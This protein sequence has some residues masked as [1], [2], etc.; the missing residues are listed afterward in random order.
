M[1]RVKIFGAGSIG[2]HLAH[3][4]RT[5]GATVTVCD[6]SGDALERMR[7]DIYPSRYKQWDEGIT[8]SSVEAQPQGG[9]DLICI[10]TPPDSHLPLALAA[11]EEQ[12]GAILIE[13]PACPP[14]LEGAQA[15]IDGG[16]K[17]STQLFIGYDHVV[18]RAALRVEQ[19]MHD[20]AVGDVRT[21]DVE[22][23]EHWQGIFKAHPWLNGPADTYLGFWKRGG[24]ASG[25]HSHA[26]NLWQH[27]AHV[28]GGGRVT[29]TDCLLT[30]VQ[31]GAAHFDS[32]CSWNLRTE[33]GLVGRVVQDVVTLPARKRAV[34][35]GVD[36]AIE[37][38]NGHSPEGDAVIVHRPGKAPEVETVAKKRPDDFI[39]E[40][41]HV[42]SRLQTPAPSP[43]S[44]ER[45]LDTALLVAAAHKSEAE[46]RRIRIDWSR[47][48]LPEALV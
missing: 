5:L 30:Y 40:L 22:F 20:R 29:E 32:I 7:R 33:K 19:L 12:P 34:I 28:A 35:Q 11:L 24:G 23:R 37:W 21:L 18:G 14:S 16:R 4:A 43:I 1:K 31:D 2:N 10:G 6:V 3:A 44:L 15:V 45:G 46:R 41:S 17:G 48:Y 13:K 36:G 8:L 47:G 26:L 27:F 42:A 39:Q 38:V 9:F 25:E